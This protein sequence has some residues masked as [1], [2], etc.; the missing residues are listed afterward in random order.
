MA[1]SMRVYSA[2]ILAA[3]A[4]MRDAL[5]MQGIAAEIRGED[6]GVGPGQI[7]WHDAWP[8]LWVL[9]AAQLADAQRI[10]QDALDSSA[11]P[12]ASWTCPRC[13]EEI[14]AQFHECWNCQA[15]R[16]D[17]PAT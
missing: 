7:P 12:G 9:D 15:P 14:E 10:V 8:E 3:V 6:R 4:L 17:K 16:P 11:R 5:E 1:A 13:A 2:P